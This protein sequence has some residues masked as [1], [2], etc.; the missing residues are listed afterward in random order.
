MLTKQA[1][2]IQIVA[3]E[4]QPS[5]NEL[6][7]L[8]SA[9]DEASLD[10]QKQLESTL[11]NNDPRDDKLAQF[12]QHVTVI[13]NNKQLAAE[14]LME[15][16]EEVSINKRKVEEKEGVLHTAIGKI[17]KYFSQLAVAIFLC[18]F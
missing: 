5:Q 11:L 18:H 2:L 13:A 4:P 6:D 7:D 15:L 3:T 12:R 17:V 16:K 14:S 9:V 8:Q 10:L 1:E